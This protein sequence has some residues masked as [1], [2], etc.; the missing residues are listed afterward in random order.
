M[1]IEWVT[2]EVRAEVESKLA[3]WYG[4]EAVNELEDVEKNM[5]ELGWEYMPFDMNAKP[6]DAIVCAGDLIG[7]GARFQEEG[8]KELTLMYT[9]IDETLWGKR[10]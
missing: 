10:G 8:V 3:V 2:D 7:L 1:K 5:K 4:T 9:D 6:Y